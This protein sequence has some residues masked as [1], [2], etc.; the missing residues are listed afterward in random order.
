MKDGV[1]IFGAQGLG[2]AL[3]VEVGV[4][5]HSGHLLQHHFHP[6]DATGLLISCP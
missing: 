4:L 3:G 1:E 2:G 6:L 5:A